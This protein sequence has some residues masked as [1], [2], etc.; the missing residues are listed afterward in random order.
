MTHTPTRPASMQAPSTLLS[1]IPEG[2][3]PSDNDLSLPRR[4]ERIRRLADRCRLVVLDM[5]YQAGSGH[6]GSS[7]SCID[8][9]TVLKFDA[10]Q[11]RSDR[12]DARGDIFV[13]SK[14]HAVP[15]WYATL[16][17]SGELP[18]EEATTLRRID[19]RLQGHPDRT[20]LDLVDVSTGALGQG[21]S[22]A[23]GRAEARR[24]RG[25]NSRVFCLA[26]DGELQEGQVWEA[27][28]YAGARRLDN[29]VLVIDH[30][31]SQNDGKLDEVMPLGA[32]PEKLRAFGWNVQEID[33]HSHLAIL[34]ALT[35]AAAHATQPSVVVAHTHKGYLGR[36]RVLLKGSHS[37]TLGQEEYGEAVEYLGEAE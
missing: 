37:G 36:G 29:L 4:V 8:V 32:L 9:L 24:L 10:M 17:M 19:S 23:I 34:D 1:S 6:V 21:L 27:F 16:I 25:L 5:I 20:R 22:V 2:L 15:A 30:N 31:K 13:L 33:G 7:L 3:V 14:G 18:P 11:W 35:S 12:S 26:G 28:M